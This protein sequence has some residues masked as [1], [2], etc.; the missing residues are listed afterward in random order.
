VTAQQTASTVEQLGALGVA[1]AYEAA[2]R[3]GLV[4]A[5]LIQIVPGSRAAGAARIARCGQNDNRTVH[6]A[7]D[8]LQPGEV[9]VISMPTPQPIGVIGELLVTQAQVHGA[10]GI[11]VDAAVRDVDDLREIGLPIWSRWIRASGATKN[12]RGELDVPVEF[13]G[14]RIEPGDIVVMD[15]DGVVVV[16]IARAEEVLAASRERSD[17]EAGMRL[18]LEQGELSYDIHG[19]RAEDQK[20]G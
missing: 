18:R 9:L 2:G 11:L 14:V 8:A 12:E 7:M 17:R 5:D 20:S 6:A 1:T 16:P 10:A 3:T 13:G 4:D 19:L 15:S